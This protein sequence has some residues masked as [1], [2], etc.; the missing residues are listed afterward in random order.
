MGGRPYGR[1]AKSYAVADLAM[2]H[3][4]GSG[5]I[6]RRRSNN[7]HLDRAWRTSVLFV[8]DAW[9][10]AADIDNACV[11]RLSIDDQPPRVELLG[12]FTNQPAVRS[13]MRSPYGSSEISLVHSGSLHTR[14]VQVRTFPSELI[15]SAN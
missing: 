6:A 5:I 10:A 8:Q 11:G 7:A 13:E 3:V 4:A 15:A 9:G 2:E 1:R 12:Q 14:D